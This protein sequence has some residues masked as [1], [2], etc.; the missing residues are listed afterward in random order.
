MKLLKI[1]KDFFSSKKNNEKLKVSKEIKAVIKKYELGELSICSTTTYID[2][3]LDQYI[4]SIK[5][6]ELRI[7]KLEYQ[8]KFSDNA[9]LDLR[10]LTDSI[11]TQSLN[12]K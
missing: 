5:N 3:I 2:Q 11:S 6:L 7:S 4:Q 10:K 12:K 1:I 9:E 8:N